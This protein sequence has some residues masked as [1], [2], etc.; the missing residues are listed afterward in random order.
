[1]KVKATIWFA[2]TQVLDKDDW[3]YDRGPSFASVE[4]AEEWLVES[5][6]DGLRKEYGQGCNGVK[7]I[8]LYPPG[9][10]E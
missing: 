5:Y 10:D 8:Y 9:G 1:M 6:W 7:L 3:L 2:T 4:E